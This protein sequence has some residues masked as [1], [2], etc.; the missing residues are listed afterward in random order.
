MVGTSN[1]Y[2]FLLHDID[3]GEKPRW[4][5]QEWIVGPVEGR[6]QLCCIASSEP[7]AVS[8]GS[9]TRWMGLGQCVGVWYASGRPASW[10]VVCRWPRPPVMA[11]VGPLRPLQHPVEDDRRHHQRLLGGRHPPWEGA[12]KSW[13]RVAKAAAMA[14]LSGEVPTRSGW[15]V[16]MRRL[17][18]VCT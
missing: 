12:P 2:R 7:V 13:D 3:M 14:R 15:R 8:P 10:S 9:S 5:R 18:C 6:H 11:S 4:K 16:R 17:Y 1:V